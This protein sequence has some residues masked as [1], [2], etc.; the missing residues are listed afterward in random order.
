VAESDDPGERALGVNGLAAWGAL[1]AEIKNEDDPLA[2]SKLRRQRVRLA[3]G[4]VLA[5]GV[6]VLLIAL[7][8]AGSSPTSKTRA[9]DACHV[10]IADIRGNSTPEFEPDGGRTVTQ[11]GN[12]WFVA[13]YVRDR[14]RLVS[15]MCRVTQLSDDTFVV[16]N[17][18]INE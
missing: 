12:E 9:V 7:R 18:V 6:S 14:P 13:G 4:V 1:S 2:R 10:R 17:T 16:Y 8:L 11:N 3:V 5:T 15:Y